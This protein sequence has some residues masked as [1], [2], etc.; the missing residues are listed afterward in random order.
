[1]LQGQDKSK[2]MNFFWIIRAI[3]QRSAQ[4]NNQGLWALND[5]KTFRNISQ[6]LK[7]EMENMD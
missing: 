2:S 3:T 5:I 4:L 6:N 1:M 7:K